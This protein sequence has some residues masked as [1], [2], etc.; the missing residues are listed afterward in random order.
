M[1]VKKLQ[2]K[3]QGNIHTINGST[4]K[5]PNSIT[6]DPYLY[7]FVYSDWRGS[8]T[9]EPPFDPKKLPSTLRGFIYIEGCAA[10]LVHPYYVSG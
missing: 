10:I 2:I 7:L 6:Q 4:L 5:V 9:L 3:Y 1:I 8:P